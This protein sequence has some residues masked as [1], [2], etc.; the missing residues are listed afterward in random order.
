[1]IR[2]IYVALPEDLRRA[3][4][5]LAQAERRRPQE[6]AALLIVEGLA[7]SGWLEVIRPTEATERDPEPVA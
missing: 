6:Q 4:Y 1:M 7:R 3:L 2:S 5:A